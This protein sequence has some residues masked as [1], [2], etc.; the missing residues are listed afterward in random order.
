MTNSIKKYD[1]ESLKSAYNEYCENLKGVINP[2][3]SLNIF[4]Q[5]LKDNNLSTVHAESIYSAVKDYTNTL[6]Y[7]GDIKLRKKNRK[8]NAFIKKFLMPVAA[9]GLGVGG[10]ATAVESMKLVAGQT[11]GWITV[12]SNPAS[13]FISTTV[14][15]VAIGAA[16]SAAVILAKKALTTFYYNKAYDSAKENLNALENGTDLEN[17]KI[18]SLMNKVLATKEKIL[19]TKEGKWYTA[20]FRFLKR[21]ALNA[22]NRNRVHHIERVTKDLV[23]ELQNYNSILATNDNIQKTLQT[24]SNAILQILHKINTFVHSDLESSK[25]FSMLTCK[26]DKKNHKH[27]EIIENLDIYENLKM[28]LDIVKNLNPTNKNEKVALKQQK[29]NYKKALKNY[30]QKLSGAQKLLNDGEISNLSLLTK[31]AIRYNNQHQ[32]ESTAEFVEI[33]KE[34]IE[35]VVHTKENNI[36]T[37]TVAPEATATFVQTPQNSQEEV[38]TGEENNK[39]SKEEIVEMIWNSNLDPKQ[40]AKLVHKVNVFE[41]DIDL[42]I[43]N[44]V[45][46]KTEETIVT[47]EV[48]EEKEVPVFELSRSMFYDTQLT[49]VDEVNNT[50]N[51]TEVLNT[52]DNNEEIVEIENSEKHDENEYAIIY[53]PSFEIPEEDDLDDEPPLDETYSLAKVLNKEEAIEEPIVEGVYEEQPVVEEPKVEYVPN[54]A[55]KT[56]KTPSL[57]SKLSIKQLKTKTK[58]TCDGETID[59]ITKNKSQEDIE[60]EFH[61]AFVQ[62]GIIEP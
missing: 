6:T 11:A 38:K 16:T 42:S 28:Y 57:I 35:E 10:V 12:T 37:T 47:E 14:P 3:D 22:V 59:I 31:C 9:T 5:F 61:D 46:E 41:E 7:S 53:Q 50:I 30:N 40:K 39:P 27:K 44:P 1:L 13:I 29:K 33:A 23:G 17:L 58:I 45:E 4:T 43:L 34:V 55:P 54:P 15:G 32:Q 49:D 21:H 48:S 24:K 18:T 62:F 19:D 25:L 51:T 20:P 26:D 36:T 2:N 60:N 52:E 56:V 8:L